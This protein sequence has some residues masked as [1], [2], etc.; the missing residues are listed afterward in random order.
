MD[1]SGSLGGRRHSGQARDSL[2][3]TTSVHDRAEILLPTATL[4][5]AVKKWQ[6]GLYCYPPPA[7]SSSRVEFSRSM[8]SLERT[9]VVSRSARVESG[10]V[11]VPSSST[12]VPV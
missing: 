9:D 7:E 3:F 11:A 1:V 2:V 8:C 12:T 4:A 5:C 6:Q 10:D